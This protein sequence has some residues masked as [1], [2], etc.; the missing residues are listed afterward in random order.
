MNGALARILAR[1]G[2]GALALW[3]VVSPGMAEAVASDPDVQL[4]LNVALAAAV[5]VVV[6]GYYKVA[7]HMG[8]PT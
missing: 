2:V 4:V 5:S 8:W 3:G 6:E 7:K 1:Y